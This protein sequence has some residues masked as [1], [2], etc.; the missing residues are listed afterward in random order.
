MRGRSFC[1]MGTLLGLG[2]CVG[3]QD[4]NQEAFPVLE[5][6]KAAPETP[7][8]SRLPLPAPRTDLWTAEERDEFEARIGAKIGALLKSPERIAMLLGK[9]RGPPRARPT[10]VGQLHL[11]Y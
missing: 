4:P 2:A 8:A 9:A 5:S 7:A 6:Q 11:F 10:L 1:F 3:H